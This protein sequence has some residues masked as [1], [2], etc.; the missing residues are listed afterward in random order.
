M[1]DTA[2]KFPYRP[3]QAVLYPGEVGDGLYFVARGQV[4]IEYRRGGS[5]E[6]DIDAGKREEDIYDIL[7]SG[8]GKL[9]GGSAIEDGS[10]GPSADPFPP[11][12]KLREYH[13]N[14][15]FQQ[16]IKAAAAFELIKNEADRRALNPLAAAAAKPKSPKQK[17]MG[18]MLK[19]GRAP[20]PIKTKRRGKGV[21]P[22]SASD[23]S[24][25]DSDSSDSSDSDSDSGSSYTT[26]SSY[27]SDS[28][29]DTKEIVVK[30]II[31]A[32]SKQPFFGESFLVADVPSAVTIRASKET[33]GA[34]LIV[35]SRDRVLR[36]L[37]TCE[38]CVVIV[39]LETHNILLL[40]GALCSPAASC[41][42][43]DPCG[44]VSDAPP[45]RN[46]ANSTS[47]PCAS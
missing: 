17:K 47:T 3:E 43:F 40:C 31:T 44:R 24:G 4:E 15:D 22:S 32:E 36:F 12:A 25:S 14:R 29:E 5:S 28:S 42:G 26:D 46:A 39:V 18:T 30:R 37:D 45:S 16:L 41:N 34:D 20:S 8:K 10:D 23:S 27:D 35:I 38:V 2:F 1:Q 9:F 6:E 11:G 33:G 19:K 21:K 7:V 13:H